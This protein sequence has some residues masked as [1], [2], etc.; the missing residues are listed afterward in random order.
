[1]YNE[2]TIA[3]G[4]HAMIA[5]NAN[6]RSM[7]MVNGRWTSNG[8]PRRS[9][10]VG[11]GPQRRGFTLIELLVVV[12]IIALLAAILFPAFAHARDNARRTTCLSNEKQLG[13]AWIQYTQ[14]Y[15]EHSPLNGYYYAAPGDPNGTS[16]DDFT[17]K[18]LDPLGYPHDEYSYPTSLQQG[19]GL[20]G[21]NPWFNLLFPY[22]KSLQLL[23]CPSRVAG[24][25]DGS[26]S[27]GEY[28]DQPLTWG[29]YGMN[30]YMDARAIS[31]VTVPAETMAFTE[32][33]FAWLDGFS[34]WSRLSPRHGY[35]D[36]ASPGSSFHMNNGG[37]N[38]CYLD[39]HAKWRN[40]NWMAVTPSV[41][42]P[43]VTHWCRGGAQV[44]IL[45]DGTTGPAANPTNPSCEW[46][47]APFRPY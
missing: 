31:T 2:V 19:N 25:L 34:N 3:M 9:G 20:S 7:T 39:G 26:G 33:K 6:G 42:W 24:A 44:D 13:L 43:G 5:K 11:E 27:N 30:L 12:A 28:N 8:G 35:G 46:Y 22:Y 45:P 23:N 47:I 40:M 29:E 21:C 18:Q 14:D 32:A 1:M 4:A 38:V 16:C 15:D 37:I 10:T 36:Q 41:M 17:T